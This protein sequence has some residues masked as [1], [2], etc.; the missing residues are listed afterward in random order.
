MGTKN[1]PGNYDCYAH[2]DPDE[3]MFVLLA[4]DKHAPVLVWLWTVLRELDN[5][6]PAKVKEA[7]DCIE[8][9]FMWQ[10][11][12]GRPTV[13]VGQAALA[14]VFEL[15]RAANWTTRNRPNDPTRDEIFRAYLCRTKFE[16][17]PD[18]GPAEPPPSD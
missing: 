4:R 11:D 7:R 9:M 16:G 17:V 10:A 6:D 1:N 12:R 8:A 18:A 15:I 5:E 3:P 13:G 2:A 14:G